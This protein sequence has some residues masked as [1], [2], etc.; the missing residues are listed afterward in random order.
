[1]AREQVGTIERVVP[2]VVE[3]PVVQPVQEG[4]GAEF[5]AMPPI[6][7][8][9]VETKMKVLTTDGDY[10]QLNN[11]KMLLG[12]S[13]RFM[14]TEAGFFRTPHTTRIL[15]GGHRVIYIFTDVTGRFN[16]YYDV[17]LRAPVEGGKAGGAMFPTTTLVTKDRIFVPV[18]KQLTQCFSITSGSKEFYVRFDTLISD[19]KE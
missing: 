10:P 14:L 7:R 3:S 5:P 18:P 13:D 6:I 9:E 1:V 11:F 15:W 4:S 16:L 2:D 17:E 19:I 8:D 12:L